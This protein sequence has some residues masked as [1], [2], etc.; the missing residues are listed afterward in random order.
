MRRI[1][2]VVGM[3]A[4]FLFLTAPSNARLVARNISLK[5]PSGTPWHQTFHILWQKGEIEVDFVE[6][7]MAAAEKYDVAPALIAAVIKARSNDVYFASYESQS[8]QAKRCSDYQFLKIE[9]VAKLL[10]QKTLVLCHPSDL[11]ASRS[12]DG[13]ISRARDYPILSPLTIAQMG[14]TK[15][16]NNETQDLD[17]LQ[18]FYL[19]DFEPKRKAPL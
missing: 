12:S 11:V 4:V 1:G 10:N 3:A 16:K 17:C 14:F 15:M 2:Y 5:L 6:V 7:I 19:K 9:S 8:G 13:K 18:P